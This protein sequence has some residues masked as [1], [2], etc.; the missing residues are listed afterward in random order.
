MDTQ[1]PGLLLA[2]WWWVRSRQDKDPWS[3]PAILNLAK[4]CANFGEDGKKIF[5]KVDVRSTCTGSNAQFLW[6]TICPGSS[7][8]FYIVTCY[9]KRVTTSWTHSITLWSVVEWSFS[10]LL[11]DILKSIWWFY[12]HG[13]DTINPVR[14]TDVMMS[15]PNIWIWP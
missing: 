1:Y 10:L 7:D 3:N 9:I 14:Y 11:K 15:E 8:P 6:L 2:R 13:S 4:F 5:F 12:W